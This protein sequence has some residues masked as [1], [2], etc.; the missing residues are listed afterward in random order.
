MRDLHGSGETAGTQK[1]TVSQKLCNLP[2]AA[3]RRAEAEK[4][5]VFGTR[6]GEMDRDDL[7][8]AM[9]LLLEERRYEDK[10]RSDSLEMDGLFNACEKRIQRHRQA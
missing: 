9:G 10:L 3:A 8:V 4:T 2:N 5:T 1:P 6:I 7:L